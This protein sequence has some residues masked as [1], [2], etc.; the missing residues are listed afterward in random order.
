MPPRRSPPRTRPDPLVCCAALAVSLA[1]LLGPAQ[2]DEPAPPAMPLQDILHALTRSGVRLIFSSETVPRELRAI[3]PSSDLPI[4]ERLQRLL[5]PFRLAAQRLADGTYVIVRAAQEIGSLEV[6]VTLERDGLIKPL[7]GATV[8]LTGTRRRAL[9]DTS[10]RVLFAELPPARYIVDA[11]YKGVPAVQR[12]VRVAASGTAERVEVRLHWE[13]VSIEEIAIESS[14]YDAGAAFGLLVPRETLESNPTT[15]S[16]AARA[17]QM[18]PGAAVAGYTAKTHIRG[19][20]DDETLYR[21]DGVTLDNPYHLDGLQSLTSAIDATLIE[22][23]TTWTGVAPIQFGD[24]IGAVVD[25]EPRA[26]TSRLFDARVS[27]RDANL[28]AG[29]PFD[30]GRGTVLAAGRLSNDYSPAQWLEP[31]TT[32]PDH[33]DYLLR[34]TWRFGA[35]TRVAVGLFATDDTRDTVTVNTIPFDQRAR[36]MSHERYVWVRL[37]QE[38]TPNLRSETLLAGQREQDHVN[39]RFF[40][41]A[42]ESGFLSASNRYAAL[43]LREELNLRLSPHCAVV[44]GAESTDATVG[45]TVADHAEFEPPFAPGLQ[46]NS[47]LSEKATAATRAVSSAVYGGVVWK[48]AA[49]TVAD[50]GVRRDARHFSALAADDSHWSVRANVRQQFSPTTVV[51]LGWG[52]STQVG[53]L[54]LVRT[55]DGALRPPTAR[56]L[57]QTNLD[58]EHALSSHWLMRLEL[59]DKHERSP[60]Q[61]YEDVLTPFALLPEVALG[62]QLLRTEGARMRG[63]EAQLESDRS[64]PLSG[65]F[66]YAWSRAE[67]LIGGHW[68]RRTWDQPNA[69]QL[70]VRW[71]SGPWQ[72]TGLLSWH[73]GWPYTPLRVSASVWQNPEAVS[74]VVGPRNSAERPAVLSLDARLSWN[75]PLA[76]GD[77]QLALELNDLTNEKAV[78][79]QAYTVVRRADGSRQLIDTPGYWMG[80]A[81]KVTI[82]WRL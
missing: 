67:D 65:S 38:I 48:A 57:T 74:I 32:R 19:S 66:S 5:A 2:A 40:V 62:N 53:V 11:H 60:F 12:A 23:A 55:V 47:Q 6:T 79:C 51:R 73:S 39:G 9:T 25:L 69:T 7:V 33:A 13:P 16:D 3:P 8:W 28:I 37:W 29:L 80:F 56:L 71:A 64:R 18:L 42:V 27:N 17:L 52:Q 22:S 70:D 1:L 45:K 30:G 4:E 76:G 81:P 72:L 43:S 21:Y 75:H 68:V 61:G 35:R 34:A 26:V 15:N 10:G 49:R 59:Y 46:P 50:L 24:Q 41:P 82:R 58:V 31:E 78:C 54:E 77:M 20:R 44:A 36:L 14:R 63:L